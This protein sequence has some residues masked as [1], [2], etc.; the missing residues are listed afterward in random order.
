MR[1]VFLWKRG[2]KTGKFSSYSRHRAGKFKKFALN[3]T[4]YNAINLRRCETGFESHPMLPV[5]LASEME[6][7]G[8][9]RYIGTVKC[10]E[11]RPV[12]AKLIQDL[13]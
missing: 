2:A 12:K 6:A 7:I 3:K 5:L 8:D 11:K 10:Y 9:Y 1:S 13:V 4:I